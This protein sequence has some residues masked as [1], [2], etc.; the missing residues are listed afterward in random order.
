VSKLSNQLIRF[1]STWQARRDLTA[2]RRRV[3]DQIRISIKSTIE[4]SGLITFDPRE[5]FDEMIARFERGEGGVWCG[6]A[7]VVLW[8]AFIE[9]GYPAWTM[10]FGFESPGGFTHAGVLVR[11]WGK[12]Y[13]FDPYFNFEFIESFEDAIEHYKATGQL[14][15]IDDGHRPRTF[16]LPQ[17][18]RDD[19][20]PKNRWRFADDDLAR[21][22]TFPAT[23]IGQWN[24]SAYSNN[25]MTPGYWQDLAR[26]G[27]AERIETFFLFPYS[28]H[29]LEN[30]YIDD[31]AKSAILKSLIAVTGCAGQPRPDARPVISRTA[32]LEN[33]HRSIRAEAV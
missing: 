21:I 3:A 6:H 26:L 14:G 15:I 28:A 19:E 31:P 16:Y 25:N 10:H 13:F 4:R 1:F 32:G 30:G 17:P 24:M 5:S 29:D 33:W 22:A 9:R 23:C 2:I 18:L 27:L 20:L 7:S 12:H 11:L 8:R